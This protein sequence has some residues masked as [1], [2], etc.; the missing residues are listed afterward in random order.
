MYF[1]KLEDS[2][3]IVYWNGEIYKRYGSTKEA[4]KDL[5]MKLE[6]V[7]HRAKVHKPVEYITKNM[8]L[9][10]KEIKSKESVT[11]KLAS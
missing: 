5:N 9:S 1:E 6:C 11:T 3:F 10:F 2:S 7:Y 4:A 8:K